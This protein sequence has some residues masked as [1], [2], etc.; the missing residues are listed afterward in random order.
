MLISNRDTNLDIAYP[1]HLVCYEILEQIFD[2][3]FQWAV[4]GSHGYG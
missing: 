1:M 3:L 2:D 4:F